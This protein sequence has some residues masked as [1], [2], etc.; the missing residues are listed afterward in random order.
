M[1]W[2]E[3]VVDK[4][5]SLVVVTDDVGNVDFDIVCVSTDIG[6]WVD[7]DGIV[8]MT[9]VSVV[10]V[11]VACVVVVGVVVVVADVSIVV[12]WAVFAKDILVV[13]VWGELA[14]VK[15]ADGVVRSSWRVSRWSRNVH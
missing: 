11:A 4:I 15:A 7:V 3:V 8:M 12:A 13:I 1:V 14:E 2:V 5:S 10:V 6:E 9:G